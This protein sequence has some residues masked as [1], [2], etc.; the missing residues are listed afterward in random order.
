[1]MNNPLQRRRRGG[2]TLEYA[3]LAGLAAALAVLAI[4]T[5]GA[6]FGPTFVPKK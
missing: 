4:L 3:I 6:S 2:S 5:Q 1:M